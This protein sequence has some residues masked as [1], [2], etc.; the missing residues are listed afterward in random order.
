MNSSEQE[1]LISAYVDGQLEADDQLRA[2]QLLEESE[3]ARQLLSEFRALGETL[4]SLPSVTLGSEFSDEVLRQ[5]ERAKADLAK[6]LADPPHHEPRTWRRSIVWSCLAV[7]AAVLVMVLAPDADRYEVAQHDAMQGDAAMETTAGNEGHKRT[8]QM[9]AASDM[10]DKDTMLGDGASVAAQGQALSMESASGGSPRDAQA[11]KRQGPASPV[12]AASDF[13]PS[14]DALASASSQRNA[15][16]RIAKT[17]KM[18]RPAPAKAATFA[19]SVDAVV[20]L[21]SNK[22]RHADPR[23][24]I[25]RLLRKDLEERVQ[26]TAANRAFGQSVEQKPKETDLA[27]NRAKKTDDDSDDRL[28]DAPKT[29]EVR[30]TI[31]GTYEQLAA[32]LAR[33]QTEDPSIRWVSANPNVSHRS[34]EGGAAA[35]KL[36]SG[37]TREGEAPAEPQSQAPQQPPPQEPYGGHVGKLAD[38]TRS[39]KDFKIQLRRSLKPGK[40][41]AKL[42][43]DTESEGFQAGGGNGSGDK[44]PLESSTRI[45]RIVVVVQFDDPTGPSAIA[46]PPPERAKDR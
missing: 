3:E 36:H 45:Y 20:T 38:T 5:A 15:R 33:L 24:M 32:T 28:S 4:R 14:D 13:S 34:A 29:G 31:E 9:Q 30:Y 7:A 43:E 1:K 41:D 46:P 21:R 26:Q 27:R 6:P 44:T 22:S 12:A 25:D 19:S 8:L 35:P 11:S 17:G 18:R 16:S 37:H 40:T 39:D 42:S 10:A 23:A 2:E